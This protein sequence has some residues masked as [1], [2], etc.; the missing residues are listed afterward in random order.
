MVSENGISYN[1]QICC[2]TTSMK[3]LFPEYIEPLHSRYNMKET[4][5]IGFQ[6]PQFLQSLHLSFCQARI[7]HIHIVSR[8]CH[9]SENGTVT[10]CLLN[11]FKARLTVHEVSFKTQGTNKIELPFILLL[12]EKKIILEQI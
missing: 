2:N 10:H 5:S 8:N 4:N 3:V 6:Q 7:L 12:S 11:P 9:I 1:S